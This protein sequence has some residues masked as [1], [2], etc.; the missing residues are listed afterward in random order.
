MEII[1]LGTS[2]IFHQDIAQLGLAP[3]WHANVSPQPQPQSQPP[4]QP[5]FLLSPSHEGYFLYIAPMEMEAH[6]LQ[7]RPASATETDPAL[8]SPCPKLLPSNPI[9]HVTFRHPG[10][11]DLSNILF[12]LPTFD[13]RE[14]D[15][16]GTGG[17]GV[18]HGTAL[19]ACSIIACN[20]DGFL[21]PTLLQLPPDSSRPV[22]TSLD[23]LLTAKVYYFY[24][25]AWTSPLDLEYPVCP[26]F[27]DWQFPH[28]TTPKVWKDVYV[29][30]NLPHCSLQVLNISRNTPDQ[31]HG[32]QRRVSSPRLSS[33]VTS[34]VGSPI[35]TIAPTQ[36]IL[37]PRRNTIGY[38]VLPPSCFCLS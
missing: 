19:W 7:L 5:P 28:D 16:D 4:P 8:S 20:I 21:H 36:P 1:K 10:Y 24:P 29:C 31:S 37:F 2:A 18:H 30:T 33:Y 38:V 23:A 12:R 25:R 11:P 6:S 27:H 34:P 22:E 26:S 32:Y 17:W 15:D 14:P 35:L 3:A 13:G 9:A